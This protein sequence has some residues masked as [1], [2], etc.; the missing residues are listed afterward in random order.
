MCGQCVIDNVRQSMMSRRSLLLGA[1]ATGAAA[2]ALGT[3]R[4]A[5]A[6]TAEAGGVSGRFSGVAD[7]THTLVPDFPT[8]SGK[9]QFEANQVYFRD[10]DGY[11]LSILTIDEHTGT[12]VDAPLHFST[13]GQSVDEIPVANLVAPLV[14]VDIAA[15]AADDA[16]AQ[17]TPDDLKAWISANGEMPDRCC[18]AMHS[19]WAEKV[20]G[21]G[22]RN[23]DGDGVMHFPG[24][25][26]EAAAML[27]EE[28]GAI[29]IGVDTLSLDHGASADFGT[30]NS[31]LPTNR[32]GVECLAGLGA[33][34]ASGA[35]IV[36]GA[37][38]HKGGSGGP[39]RV[40]ALTK[41]A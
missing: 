16:D 25:H 24:F 36:L 32:W 9:P 14:I 1:A 20:G 34:P 4:P 19:G 13:D 23:A 7:L 39:A 18:V 15:R 33:L 40:F 41:A 3:P 8:F 27:M 22:F 5:L 30:H 26:P 10:K 31:W 6:Q 17:V 38:K 12:H 29:G 21:D 35:M 2:A 11:N 28:T 37:P